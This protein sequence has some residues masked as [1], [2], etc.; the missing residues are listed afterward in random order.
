MR[1]PGWHVTIKLALN[2]LCLELPFLS[3]EK[4]FKANLRVTCHPWSDQETRE[5]L[6]F[7][8]QSM[9]TNHLDTKSNQM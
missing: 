5:G 2:C 1:T 9:D 3:R 6:Y 4:K 8:F 7:T